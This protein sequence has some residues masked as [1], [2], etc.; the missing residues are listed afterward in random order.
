[1]ETT[2]RDFIDFCINV[3]NT[4]DGCHSG[5]FEPPGLPHKWA[6]EPK[7]FLFHPVLTGSVSLSCSVC[8]KKLNF[9]N[10]AYGSSKQQPRYLKSK[11]RNTMLIS[12]IY[13]CGSP[14]CRTYLAHDIS[15]LQQLCSSM[16][17]D[18]VLFSR[19]AQPDFKLDK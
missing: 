9:N 7:L 3:F 1:M 5:L 8:S 6:Y 19:T 16:K 17:Q 18:F 15:V 2:G 13:H 12:A 14:G 10:W 11:G 4:S